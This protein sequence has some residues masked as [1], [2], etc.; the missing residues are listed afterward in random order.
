MRETFFFGRERDPKK[1]VKN[2]VFRVLEFPG[3]KICTKTRSMRVVSAFGMISLSLSLSTKLF[4]H[5]HTTTT[6]T[7]TTVQYDDDDDDSSEESPLTEEEE[8]EEE[9]KSV[10]FSFLW[11]S[12][13]V[14]FLFCVVGLCCYYASNSFLV[15]R[16]EWPS[17][18]PRRL[19]TPTTK[20]TKTR[21]EGRRRRVG[22]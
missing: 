16:I 12:F 1:M 7:T 21:T 13:F 18:A 5:K 9:R 14:F 22:K 2:V 19:R 4:R 6:T 8:E 11:W 17:A 20:T 10:A 15:R 3:K